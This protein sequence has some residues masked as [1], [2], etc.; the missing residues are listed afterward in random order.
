MPYEDDSFDY[1]TCASSFHHHPNPFQS[2][3]EMVRVLKLGGKL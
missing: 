3:K 1:V 2:I